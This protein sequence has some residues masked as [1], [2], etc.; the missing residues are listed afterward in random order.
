M[1]DDAEYE[2]LHEEQNTDKYENRLYNGKGN[3][4]VGYWDGWIIK[5]WWWLR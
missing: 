1:R 5:K 4:N 2:D 3:W